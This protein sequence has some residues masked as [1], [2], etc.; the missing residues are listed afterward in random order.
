VKLNKLAFKSIPRTLGGNQPKPIWIYLDTNGAETFNYQNLPEYQ[1]S[2]MLP[3]NKN[4]MTFYKTTGRQTDFHYWRDLKDI[5]TP[6]GLKL[7]IRSEAE[8]TNQ[9]YWSFQVFYSLSF[10]GMVLPVTESLKL[11]QVAEGEN[12]IKISMENKNQEDGELSDSWG[13]EEE[14]IDEI[15]NNKKDNQHL[16]NQNRAVLKQEPHVKIKNKKNNL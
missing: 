1:G 6:V 3:I 14:E 9:V 13:A 2:K 8:P 16:D 7:R 12:K 15:I 5:Q 4:T 11:K 10:R